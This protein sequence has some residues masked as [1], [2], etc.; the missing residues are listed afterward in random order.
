MHRIIRGNGWCSGHLLTPAVPCVGMLLALAVQHMCLVRHLNGMRVFLP[1]MNPLG[2]DPGRFEIAEDEEGSVVGCCQL[3][4]LPEQLMWSLRTLIVRSDMRGQGIGSELI[5]RVLQRV[6]PEDRVFLTTISGAEAL[7]GRFG[8]RVAR[9]QEVPR[10]L[11]LEVAA[12]S[13][14]ARIVTGKPLI[15]MVRDGSTGKQRARA[16]QG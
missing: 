6:A 7:Y 4:K 14:V 9:L 2:L 5:Q 3:E 15:V 16:P 10:S 1:R 11:Y 13:V 8:F 12:G